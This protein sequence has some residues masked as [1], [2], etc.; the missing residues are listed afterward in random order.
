MCLQILIVFILNLFLFFS[1][2]APQILNE[3]KDVQCSNG[4]LRL[5][6]SNIIKGS[7]TTLV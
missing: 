5:N 3:N 6:F 7:G 4:E 1:A 2:A